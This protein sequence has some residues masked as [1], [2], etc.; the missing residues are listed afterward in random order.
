MF[1]ELIEALRC[2]RPHEET[3]LVASTTRSEGRHIVDGVL[4]CPGCGAEFPIASGVAQF[5][6]PRVPARAE[7]ASAEIAMRLAAFLELTDA[8]GFALLV[9]RWGAHADQL[10]RLSDTPL[11]LVNPPPD[12]V[13]DV[14]GVVLCRDVMPF[15]PAS[16][17]AAALHDAS[18]DLVTSLLRIVKPGGR[19][20]GPVSLELP[21]RVTELVRDDRV[22]VAEKT[23]ASDATPRL[24]PIGRA[25]PL[26]G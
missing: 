21:D 14:A 7:P 15:A 24:V 19:V 3:Q 6:D 26:I 22:W 18:A 1:V 12:V 16:A 23:T 2:P 25:K 10:R 5:G 11:V 20:I 9:G 8:R 13:A 17:R 4:G